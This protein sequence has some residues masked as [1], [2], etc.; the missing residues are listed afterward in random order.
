MK[1]Q[2]NGKAGVLLNNGYANIFYIRDQSGVLRAV[3]VS[4]RGV[5]CYVIAYVVSCP[6]VWLGGYQVFSRKLLETL[7]AA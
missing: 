3:F 2:A 5:G 4:W 7:A 6:Y 1:K